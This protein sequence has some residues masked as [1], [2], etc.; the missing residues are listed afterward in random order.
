M[1]VS[2]AKEQKEQTMFGLHYQWVVFRDIVTH[3]NA[4]TNAQW[5]AI[6]AQSGMTGITRTQAINFVTARRDEVFIE[7]ATA[8]NEWRLTP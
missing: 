1:A 6:A 8:M 5:D 3:L 7:L 2:P 4:L